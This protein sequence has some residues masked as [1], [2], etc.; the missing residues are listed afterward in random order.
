MKKNTNIYNIIK[1]GVT[2]YVTKKEAVNMYS[3]MVAR[4]NQS[5]TASEA[6]AATISA[7]K[8]LNNLITKNNI[9]A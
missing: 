2:P 5:T 7:L 3:S 6:K 9:S 8:T 1:N 4:T